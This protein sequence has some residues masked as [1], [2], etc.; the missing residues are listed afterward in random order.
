MGRA[1]T[2]KSQHKMMREADTYDGRLESRVNHGK[3]A[4]VSAAAGSS[5]A[6]VEDYQVFWGLTGSC[7][8]M[9]PCRL[10]VTRRVGGGDR[11]GVVL[12]TH[13]SVLGSFWE[14]SD[15]S[16]TDH[17]VCRWRNNLW[18]CRT[19]TWAAESQSCKSKGRSR[20]GEN[21]SVR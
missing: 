17:E 19:A 15:Y 21:P 1:I 4:S 14:A 20:S 7:G 3:P 13:V 11:D 12:L 9:R 2:G 16:E 18:S 5:R 6:R 10:I 8:L